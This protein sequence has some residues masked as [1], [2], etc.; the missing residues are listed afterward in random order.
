MAFEALL[1]RFP[2]LQLAQTEVHW[3]TLVNLRGLTA[4][5]LHGYRTSSQLP[6]A[7]DANSASIT[8]ILQM[9]SSTP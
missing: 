7:S 1:S 6:L 2:H 5:P 3:R 9:A 4:L 8:R